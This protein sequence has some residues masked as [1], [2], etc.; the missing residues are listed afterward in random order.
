MS[1]PSL[2]AYNIRQGNIMPS[3][4]I[5][6]E[7]TEPLKESVVKIAIRHAGPWTSANVSAPGQITEMIL[8]WNMQ[9]DKP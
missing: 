8:R 9:V 3:D 1:L 4:G 5:H 7:G 6:G 2:T